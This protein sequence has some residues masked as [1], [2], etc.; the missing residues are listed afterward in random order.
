MYLRESGIQVLEKDAN[1]SEDQAK[2][3]MIHLYPLTEFKYKKGHRFE[4]TTPTL[5]F[6]CLNAG[7]GFK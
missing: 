5:S 7:V 1:S 2:S 6:L 4:E 3:F